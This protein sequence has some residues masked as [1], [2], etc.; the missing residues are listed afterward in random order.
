MSTQYKSKIYT[1]RGDAGKTNLV[2]GTVVSKGDLRVD[3]YG[4]IDELN[5]YI[6]LL[7]SSLENSSLKTF[8]HKIQNRLF[9][10][11]SNMACERKFHDK[12]QLGKINSEDVLSIENEIDKMESDLSPLSNFILPSGNSSACMAHVCRTICRKTERKMVLFEEQNP[13]EQDVTY[14]MFINRLSDYFFVLA[15]FLNY[16]KEDVEIIWEK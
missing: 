3:L 4:T 7:D 12:Y 1:K 2:S 13:A 8:L 10:M 14:L 6:G 9:V 5:S 15:R 11:G 16:K